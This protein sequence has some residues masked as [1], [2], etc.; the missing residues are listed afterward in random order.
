M[1]TRYKNPWHD[2]KAYGRESGP[3]FFET[4]AKPKS[5]RG[6]LVYNRIPGHVWDFV[7]DGVC[8]TQRAGITH[9]ERE[10]DKIL[11]AIEKGEEFS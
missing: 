1:K 9:M 4:D 7:K 6:F 3:E 10:I 8:V 5:Y 11:E 2:K